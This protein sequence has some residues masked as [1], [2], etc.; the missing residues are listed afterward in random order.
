MSLNW[1]KEI[2]NLLVVAKEYYLKKKIDKFSFSVESMRIFMN[3]DHPQKYIL[4]DH[5]HA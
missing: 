3:I 5:H 1:I 2:E 4:S